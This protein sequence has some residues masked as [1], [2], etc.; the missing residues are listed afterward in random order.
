[1]TTALQLLE[2][3]GYAGIVAGFAL[4]VVIGVRR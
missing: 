1:M 4:F 3:L 2:A